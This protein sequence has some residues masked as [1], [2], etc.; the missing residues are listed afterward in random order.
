MRYPPPDLGDS[1]DHC[2]QMLQRMD[3]GRCEAWRDEV[4]KLLIFVGSHYIADEITGGQP[5]LLRPV[6]SP[7]W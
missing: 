4:D 6:F 1:W 5:R 3:K 7:Q 2:N